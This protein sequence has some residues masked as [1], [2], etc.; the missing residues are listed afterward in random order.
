MTDTS[1]TI[2]TLSNGALT[3]PGAVGDTLPTFTSGKSVTLQ[4]LADVDGVA[5]DTLREYAR[6][7][8]ESTTN[9]GTDIRGRPW[10][11]QSIHPD[12]GFES[13]LVRLEP[14]AGVGPLRSWWVVVT[15]GSI[16]TTPVGTGRRITLECYL[17]GEYDDYGT[18]DYVV[19]EFE[20]DV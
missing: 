6:Y 17:L 13:V 20:S 1:W 8:N 4:F 12:A 11:H 19:D 18:R 3:V 14:S 2:H 7:T 9:T 15:G 5:F 16:T 10:F